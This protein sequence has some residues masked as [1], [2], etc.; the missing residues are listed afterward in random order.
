MMK[1]TPILSPAGAS[2]QE[3]RFQL[4][5]Q[6]L[7][8]VLTAGYKKDV[9][10]FSVLFSQRMNPLQTESPDTSA[11]SFQQGGLQKTGNPLDLAIDGE[12]FF[13]VM[14][15]SG[16][17]YTRAGHFRLDKEQRLTN[18]DGFPVLGRGGEI[19]LKGKEITVEK[20][21]V[22]KADGSE[23][24]RISLVTFLDP[25]RLKKEGHTLFTMEIPAEERE[26][27]N[28]SVL[29]GHLE[30]SNVDPIEEM[31][32]LIDATRTYESCLKAVQSWDEMDEKM[33]NDLGRV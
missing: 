28:A 22:I 33:A 16:V 20:G 6:N 29:Q 1:T 19:K 10:V 3:K 25:G 31:V 4:I 23:A 27:T 30:Q 26:V 32:K 12:G 2:R 5:S 18:A 24:G 17:R 15:P 8:N 11:I 13:K 21:G 9:P 14:T 7:S